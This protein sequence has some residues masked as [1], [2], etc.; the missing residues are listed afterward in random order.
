MLPDSLHPL[1]GS[2]TQTG[3]AAGQGAD[4]A[5]RAQ[6]ATWFAYFTPYT[7]PRHTALIAEM[8]IKS[9]VRLEAFGPSLDG[10]DVDV[11]TIGAGRLR[12]PSYVLVQG[13]C[14]GSGGCQGYGF[15]DHTFCSGG[16]ACARGLSGLRMAVRPC[17]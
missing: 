7:L 15:H 1:H 4:A 10:R 6:D 17:R 13:G 5:A 12:A 11:L 2:L 9:R 3:A 16:R 8:Q 14:Q